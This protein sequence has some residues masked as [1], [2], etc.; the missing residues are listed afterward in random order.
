MATTRCPFTSA[1]TVAGIAAPDTQQHSPACIT[2]GVIGLYLRLLC[3]AASRLSIPTHSYCIKLQL[4]LSVK[5]RS[6][7]GW[8]PSD[9]LSNKKARYNEIRRMKTTK[10]L[11]SAPSL[12]SAS[13]NLKEAEKIELT[14][15]VRHHFAATPWMNETNG[16]RMSE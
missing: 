10:M 6:G 16:E 9:S 15:D 8:T 12:H 4:W 3:Y 1:A 5:K 14:C 2:T 13:V 11:A 7:R